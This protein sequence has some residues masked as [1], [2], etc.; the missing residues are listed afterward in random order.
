[1]EHGLTMLVAIAI[2]SISSARARRKFTDYQK[3]KT[4][5]VGFT[6]ALFIILISIPWPFSP[7]ANR[8]YLRMF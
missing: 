8:P 6:V 4:L 3:F 7:L 1:M 2:I 5:A